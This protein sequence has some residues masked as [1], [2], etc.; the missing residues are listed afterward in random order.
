MKIALKYFF[1]LTSLMILSIIVRLIGI[2][3]YGDDTIEYEWLTLLKNL[4]NYGIISL[5]GSIPS[6]FMPPL[7]L[8]VLYALQIVTPENFQ[9]VKVV[10][11]FQVFLSIIT[12]FVFYNL[13]KFFFTKNWSLFNSFL[14]S[15][16]PLNVYTVTQISSISLQIFLLTIYLYL[17][18]SLQKKPKIINFSVISFS[19]VSGA[20]MLLRGEFYLIFLISLIYMFFFKK[21]NIKKFLFIFLIS[22]FVIS[23]YLIRN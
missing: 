19:I 5:E 13:N 1:N 22:V 6:V 21:I 8:F 18:F 15:V 3:L 2:N 9:L 14:L 11:I 7:Y 4:N 23:P 16:F 10:L 17:F 20:L 12:I